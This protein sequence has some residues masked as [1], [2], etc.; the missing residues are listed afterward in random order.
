MPN[1][2]SALKEEIGRLA[3]KEIKVATSV[4]RRVSGQHRRDIASLKRQV[5]DLERKVALIEK[6]NWRTVD[7]VPPSPERKVRFSAKG[8]ASHRKRLGLSASEYAR[9]MGVSAQ[10]LYNWEQ[11]RS[12]PRS[13]QLAKLAGLRQISKREAQK[14]LEQPAPDASSED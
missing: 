5:A 9:L 8:L 2:A 12:R 6:K 13:A 3:R 1:L 11:G 10:T 7:A 4:L 14:R